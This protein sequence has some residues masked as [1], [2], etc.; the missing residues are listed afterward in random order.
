MD[1][2]KSIKRSVDTLFG[3]MAY[4][5]GASP[6]ELYLTPKLF[7]QTYET[8]RNK[9]RDIFGDEFKN[10]NMHPISN[11]A[12][13]YGHL[14]SL[15]ATV[16]FPEGADF[17]VSPFVSSVDEG[18][19]LLK[20][21]VDFADNDLFRHYMA[22]TERLKKDF[23]DT[24]VSF[25]GYGFSGLFTEAVLMRGQTFFMDICEYPDKCLEFL[26]LLTDSLIK[27]T[28]FIRKINGE[29]LYSDAIIGLADDFNSYIAPEMHEKF[30]IPFWIKYYSALSSGP[31]YLHSEGMRRVH[32]RQL[33]LADIAHFQPSVS[34]GLTCQMLA[35]ELDIAFDWMLPSYEI[36]YM[37]DTQIDKWVADTAK[38]GPV[39]MRTQTV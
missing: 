32:L 20:K 7:K 22:Y 5:G 36:I 4:L 10:I 39:T 14:A 38:W 11:S 37:D 34:P 21:D 6:N 1:G 2:R 17:S 13:L 9:L 27:F 35:E 16:T 30:V 26:S 18:I 19:A 25:V 23:P 3:C 8:A 31:R 15:G 12:N 24:R 29:P 28:R 33:K